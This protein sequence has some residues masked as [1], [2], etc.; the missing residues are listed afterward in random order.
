MRRHAP[1][2]A[3]AV[4]LALATAAPALA[5][6]PFLAPLN[7]APQRDWVT[8]I[9]GMHEE[10]PLV[11]D[12]AL[13]PGDLF[14]TRPDGTTV[15]LDGVVQLKGLTSADAPLPTPG[16]YRLSTGLRTAREMTWAQVDGT[17][18]PVRPPRL[19]GAGGEVSKPSGGR[20]EAGEGPA[21]LAAIPEGAPT[22]K[23]TGYL[24]ADTYV[25]RGAPSDGG[26]KPTGEGL[27]IAPTANPDAVFLDKPLVVRLLLDG[28][29]LAG[30]PILARRATEAYA[31]HKTELTATTGADGRA[32]LRL[33]SA[34]AYVLEAKTAPSASGAKPP[35]KSYVA[36]LTIEATP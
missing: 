35:E 30:A 2:L 34:G 32:E 19:A 11:A 26:L 7:F 23:T 31:D 20:R 21:L 25:T 1:C 15:K 17:W 4:G 12:F 9:G 6:S 22:V 24:R 27:E 10:T 18:R 36:T 33:P 28:R 5:H 29:P 14:E 16:T 3:L 8:V 13:R